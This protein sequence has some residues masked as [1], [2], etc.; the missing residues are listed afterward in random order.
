MRIE[1]VRIK[2]F[3]VFRDVEI[4]DL[5]PL[6]VFVGAN[7][8]GKS[9]LFDVFGFLRDALKDNV[10]AALTRRGGFDDVRSRGQSDP[11]VVEVGFRA[12]DQRLVTYR[13]EVGWHDG[14]GVIE[15][16]AI[17]YRGGRTE[18]PWGLLDLRRGVGTAVTNEVDYGTT[19]AVARRD[20]MTLESPDILAIKGLGQL[21]RFGVVSRVRKAIES[22]HLSDLRL[23][24]ARTIQDAGHA[25]HL[26][27][28]GENLSQV[29]R[30]L[31]EHH[32]ERFSEI[33]ARMKHRVPGLAEIDATETVDGRLVLRFQDG[34]FKD[35][36]SAR[37]VS[38]GTIRMF[39][40]LVLL[41]DPAPHPMLFIEEPENELYPTLLTELVEEFRD[42]GRRGGGQVMVSTHSPDLLNATE[43]EEIYWL[44]K[45]DGF[46]TVHHAEDDDQLRA[47]VAEGDPPGA[48]WK[49]RL[50][51]GVDP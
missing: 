38:D 43:L 30:F 50:F 20:P 51:G 15:H 19:N 42:Y 41:H 3:R 34:A 31:Y 13:L 48:L 23:H 36:F 18:E 40:Y 1:R 24:V 45:R 27:P 33:L 4:A 8:A 21:Q 32:P 47:L 6:A 46:T 10:H 9:T 5:S 12:D 35:P 16:E 28:R 37:Q 11:V 17:E 25:E 2:N 26:S 7:G 29:T 44:E 14:R 22:W 39:A 49:Q